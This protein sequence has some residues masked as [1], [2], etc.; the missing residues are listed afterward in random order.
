MSTTGGITGGHISDAQDQ[1]C[2]GPAWETT[3]H[4]NHGSHKGL[5]AGS[6]ARHMTAFPT[7]CGLFLCTM[8]PF[9]LQGAPATFQRLMDRVIKG[10]QSYAS[11]YLDDL[12]IH[13]IQRL[14]EGHRESHPSCAGE[15]AGGGAGL[16]SN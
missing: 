14:L 4:H 7:P 2:A 8:M 3:V 6:S 9:G 5:L 10:M 11:A 15:T 12:V 13:C 16:T 1:R